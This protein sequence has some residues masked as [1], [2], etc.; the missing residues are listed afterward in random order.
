MT[1]DFYEK[2]WA[3]RETAIPVNDPTIIDRK[4]LLLNTLHEYCKIHTVLDA[5]SGDGC[6]T[7][8]LKDEGYDA[9]GMD[10]SRLAIEEASRNNPGIPFLCNQLD[11]K[12]PF[13]DGTFDAIFSTEVIEHVYGTYE[14]F[15]EMNRVLKTNGLLI[16][17]TPYHGLIK[18]LMIVLFGFDRHF[19]NIEGGHI[20]FFTKGFL[21]SVLSRSGFEVAGM[22]YIGRVRP[23]AKS[24]YLTARKVREIS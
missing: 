12:W 20:R 16:I 22:K 3:K 21:K 10:I 7:K 19:N 5:G 17:T 18:N 23:V 11:Q 13:D 4:E 15:H 9:T 14:M 6:F 8:F 2:Y 24:I 1:K